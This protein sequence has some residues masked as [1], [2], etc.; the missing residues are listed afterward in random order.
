M[1]SLCAAL[2]AGESVTISTVLATS[3]HYAGGPR[4]ADIIRT[5]TTGCTDIPEPDPGG[6]VATGAQADHLGRTGS[7]ATAAASS[8]TNASVPA[9]APQ[10][11]P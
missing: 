6:P 1:P 5:A 11:V 9:T 3:H 2:P 8:P 4:P 7:P 10:E